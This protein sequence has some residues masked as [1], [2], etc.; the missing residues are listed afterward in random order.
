VVKHLPVIAKVKRALMPCNIFREIPLEESALDALLTRQ[1][2]SQRNS[3]RRDVDAGHPKPLSSQPDGIIPAPAS[4]VDGI[5]RSY[6]PR[7][8]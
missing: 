5:A 4:D 1:L 7:L 3:R 2:A 8:D 6:L